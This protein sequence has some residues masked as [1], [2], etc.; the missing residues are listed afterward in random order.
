MIYHILMFV[1]KGHIENIIQREKLNILDQ[2]AIEDTFWH[3][4]I[5]LHYVYIKYLQN[6]IV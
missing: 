2:N 4:Y 6:I 3:I 1:F 5:Y